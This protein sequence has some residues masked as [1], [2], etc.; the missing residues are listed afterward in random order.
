MRHLIGILGFVA[1]LTAAPARAEI[2]LGLGF[3]S[4]GIG[5]SG[6]YG[7]DQQTFAQ[8]FVAPY[9]YW[10]RHDHRHLGFVGNFDYC[11]R[12]VLAPNVS[13]YIGGGLAVQQ[14]DL[15]V[16]VP[17]GVVFDPGWRAQLAVEMAPNMMVSSYSFVDLM[18]AARVK[19]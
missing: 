18:L 16:R 10:D 8:G 14:D 1:F 3:G 7:I 12:G 6:S 17:F 19:I 4:E 11:W 15:G 13:G 9:R 2:G 5:L